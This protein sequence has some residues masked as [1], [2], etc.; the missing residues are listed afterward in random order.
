MTLPVFGGISG[1][2]RTTFSIGT[3]PPA[4]ICDEANRS[5]DAVSCATVLPARAN[6]LWVLPSN[7]LK[8]VRN[9]TI[10]MNFARFPG[11]LTGQNQGR[12]F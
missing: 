8:I 10:E 3:P 6:E 12:I 5:A 11:D 1:W 9:W 4:A 7:Y 2:N